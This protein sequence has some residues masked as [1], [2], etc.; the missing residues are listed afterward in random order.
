MHLSLV[1]RHIVKSGLEP[2]MLDYKSNALPIE[3]LSLYGSKLLL[4]SEI[5]R[6]GL[7]PITSVPQA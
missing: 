2:E 6:I 3:L 1:T 4:V 7:E 5:G